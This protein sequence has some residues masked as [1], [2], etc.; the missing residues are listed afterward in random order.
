MVDVR[1]QILE[2]RET[3][4]GTPRD[5]ENA[6]L[7]GVVDGD[8]K[9]HPGAVRGQPLAL[10]DRPYQALAQAVATPNHIDPDGLLDALTGLGRQVPLEEPHQRV[11]LEIWTSPIVGRE[12]VESQ[13]SDACAGS[14][15]H[16]AVDRFG[17]M[18]VASTARHTS[19]LSPASIA[20]H[21]DCDVQTHH[22]AHDRRVALMTASICSR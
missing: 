21:D 13:R 7:G 15:F 1:Q 10:L 3:A 16:D 17:A 5:L 9:L 20:V 12:R 11:D 4:R 19:T 14:R 6:V 8:P 18:D 2:F 22:G